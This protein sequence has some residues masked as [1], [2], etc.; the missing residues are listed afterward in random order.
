MIELLAT[1]LVTLGVATD[2]IVV[3]GWCG[4]FS[5]YSKPHKMMLILFLLFTIQLQVFTYGL[6]IGKHLF[7]NNRETGKWISLVMIFSMAIMMLFELRKKNIPQEIIITLNSF[8][9]ISVLTAINVLVLG[10]ALQ[11]LS[12]QYIL[13]YIL[14][15]SIII[16]MISGWFIGKTKSV[17]KDKHIRIASFTGIILMLTGL[18][19]FLTQYFNINFKI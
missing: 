16:S 12:N 5:K 10:I 18:I 14:I 11:N 17:F 6:W 8:I 3:S 7:S 4:Y 15:P 1:V 9:P 13:F 2:N 19:L